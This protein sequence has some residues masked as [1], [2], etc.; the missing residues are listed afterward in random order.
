MS[1]DNC[2]IIAVPVKSD[3]RGDLSFIEGNNHLPFE[4]KRVYYLYDIP[5]GSSRGGH[6]H[7][8]LSQFIISL[9]GSFDLHLDDG[10]NKKTFHLNR[11][12]FGVFVCP[13]IWR[14]L[15]N[16]SSG[17]VCLVLASDV[18]HESDYLRDYDSFLRSLSR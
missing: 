14:V 6:A 17:S 2:K 10:Y 3:V 8:R 11:P 13:M 5:G 9:S 15:D 18:F 16:F 7:K 4:F 12:S 1:L